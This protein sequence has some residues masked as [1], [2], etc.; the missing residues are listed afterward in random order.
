MW[1]YL[2]RHNDPER[3]GFEGTTPLIIETGSGCSIAPRMINGV[4]HGCWVKTPTDEGRGGI[5][6]DEAFSAICFLLR[7]DMPQEEDGKWRT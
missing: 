1:L 7:I 2:H 3:S 6:V 5:W 4:S